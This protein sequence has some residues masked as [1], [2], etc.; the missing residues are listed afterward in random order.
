V[1]VPGDIDIRWNRRQVAEFVKALRG[2]KHG[3]PKAASR[4]L[5]KTAVTVRSRLVK[6]I[7]SQTGVK[8]KVVRARTWVK[9]ATYRKLHSRVSLGGLHIALMNLGARKTRKGVTYRLGQGRR[10]LAGGAFIASMPGGYH[11]GVFR[12]L[13]PE[14]LP[15]QELF[16]PAV[17]DLFETVPGLASRVTKDADALLVKY[18]AAQV[19]ML[20][21]K[22]YGVVA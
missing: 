3:W 18:L 17:M 10:Q 20:V 19:K 21:V 16:G 14:R 1:I 15:I 8:Q 7:S 22:R 11:I 6:A 5:N 4:A 9:K 12:R 13:G 2:I